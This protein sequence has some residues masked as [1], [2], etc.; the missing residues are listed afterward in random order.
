MGK[1]LEVVLAN[2]ASLEL[3]AQEEEQSAGV[4]ELAPWIPMFE[5]LLGSFVYHDQCDW[6]GLSNT[7]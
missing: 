4:S 3:A 7:S 6:Q 2:V 1:H 5:F